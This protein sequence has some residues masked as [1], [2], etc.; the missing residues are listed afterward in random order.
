MTSSSIKPQ[1]LFECREG[2]V[3][4]DV[5]KLSARNASG[6]KIANSLYCSAE[7]VMELLPIIGRRTVV[8]YCVHGHEVS[9]GA[10]QTLVAKGVD[11]RF[12]EGG[13]EA[14]LE[15]GYP[16]QTLTECHPVK[17]TR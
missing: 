14:W 15:H 9:Q 4:V 13:F 10:C 5:R 16:I 1:A 8:L 12:L 11:A 6:K 3:I 2:F 7:D 17:V